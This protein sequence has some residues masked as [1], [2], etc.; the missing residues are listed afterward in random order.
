MQEARIAWN[1]A[2]GGWKEHSHC[3]SGPVIIWRAGPTRARAK[4]VQ[5]HLGGGGGSCLSPS[6]KNEIS[7]ITCVNCVISCSW[8]SMYWISDV[9]TSIFICRLCGRVSRYT[10]QYFQ[11][12]HFIPIVGVGKRG[13]Y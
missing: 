13:A 9:G 5:R 2:P 11:H 6:P 8:L 10:K 1:D 12:A 7:I 3:H 4:C